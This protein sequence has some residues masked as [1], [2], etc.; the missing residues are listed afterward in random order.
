MHGSYDVTFG[1]TGPEI[2][3]SFLF[4]GL[5]TGLASYFFSSIWMAS[6]SYLC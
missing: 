3:L 6:M 1:N 5:T 4:Q 2:M